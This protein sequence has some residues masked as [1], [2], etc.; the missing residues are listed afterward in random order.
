MT[1]ELDPRSLVAPRG[2]ADTQNIYIYIWVKI[3]TGGL[4]P[5]LPGPG[6]KGFRHGSASWAAGFKPFE[7][8]G[9]KPNF[10]K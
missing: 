10:E 9:F 6:F 7:K 5:G 8:A 2:P 1:G 3:F 4:K